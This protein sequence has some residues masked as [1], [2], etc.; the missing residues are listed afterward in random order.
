MLSGMKQLADVGPE[1]D[2]IHDADVDAD[3]VRMLF[4]VEAVMANEI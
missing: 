3:L 4:V 1:I 2:V